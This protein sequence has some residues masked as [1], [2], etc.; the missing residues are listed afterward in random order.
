MG[1][2]SSQASRVSPPLAGKAEEAGSTTTAAGV[3]K[4][5]S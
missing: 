5:F 1:A 2:Q 4:A 3:G